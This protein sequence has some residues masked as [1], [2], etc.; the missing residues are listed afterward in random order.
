MTSINLFRFRGDVF[1]EIPGTSAALEKTLQRRIENNLEKALGVTLLASE[2]I[3]GKTH[4]GRIDTLGIDEN[5]NP[6]IVEYKRS[7]NQN[8]INQGLFYL[9]WLDDHRAEFEMLVQKKLRENVAVDWSAPRLVCI[10]GGYTRFDEYAI[11]QMRRNIELIRYKLFGDD[12]LML[13]QVNAVRAEPGITKS[14]TRMAPESTQK[15]VSNTLTTL[16]QA[17]SIVFDSLKTHLL[18]LGDDVQEQHLKTYVAFK[19]LR[20]FACVVPRKKAITVYLKVDP[21]TVNLDAGFSRDVR[22]IGHYGTGDLEVTIQS[23]EDL[24][25]AAS[26]LQRSY[27]AS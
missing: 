4:R 7:T 6:V 23:Q 1:S 17:I 16:D 14:R 15:R 26:L 12:L 9:D 5:G 24:E 27:E 21:N 8:V 20:N 2:Y 22:A 13:E 11:Q 3:T 25:R 18:D 19:R 10:A